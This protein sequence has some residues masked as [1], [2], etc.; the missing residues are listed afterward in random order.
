MLP[1]QTFAAHGERRMRVALLAGCVQQ[2]IDRNINAA[3]IRLL[4]RHGCEVVIATGAGCCGALPLHMGFEAHGKRLAHANVA[5]WSKELAAG[6]DAIVV[7]ASGCGTTVKD[8][9]HL[10]GDERA[11]TVAA[12]ARD[13]TELLDEIGMRAGAAAPYRVAYHDACSLAHGQ[14]VTRQPRELLARAGFEVVD[15]PERH[16]C[17]GSAGTY[18]LLQPEI[19]T[20]LGQ[21]KATH[22]D[23]TDADIVAAGN[24]GCM[25]QIARFTAQPI[26]H[27]VELLDWATGGPH[28]PALHN[29]R[30]RRP[31]PKGVPAASPALKARRRP[32]SQTPQPFGEPP[33]ARCRMGAANFESFFAEML[34]ELGSDGINRSSET[35]QRYGENT[36][37]GGDRPPAGVVY[38]DTTAQV[39]S[40]VRA[41]NRH[42]VPLYPISTGNNIGLGSRSASVAG[43]VVVDLGRRMNRVVEIDEKLA[44]AVVEPGVSY[45]M[46]Y[47]ELVRRGNRLMLDVTSG[48]PQG[49][50]IGNALDKGAGYSP[51]F[52]HFGFS[53]GLEIV[54]GN[55]EVLRTGDGSLDAPTL[56]NWRTSKYSFGPIL[57]G[58]FA[59]S[60]YGIVTRMGVWLLP[61]PPAIRSFHFAFPE[62]DDLDPIIELCRP[63]KLSN[64]VPTLFR[65]ANDLYLCGS[66]G[67]SPEYA[68]SNGKRAISDEGRRRLRERHGVGAWTV[69]GAFYGASAAALEPQ[70]Q[71]VRD[72]FGQS[73]K[74]RYISHDEAGSIPPLQVA[75]NAFSGI[76]SLGELGLL[77]WRPGGGNI[78]FLPGTPMDGR[79]ANEFQ[80]LCRKTY[81][82]FGLDYTVMNVCGA[83]FARGLHVITFNREDAD[84]RSRADACYRK[85][86]EQVRARGVFVGR[87][88]VDY[89]DFHM[90]QAMPA[91][92]NACADIKSRA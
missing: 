56:V 68:A 17:C 12:R 14:R 67:Q 81:E 78:W 55:G 53:C 62:D 5:A 69:S 74:A 90:Q 13:V 6:L 61:R 20:T 80:R 92:R 58:L 25:V 11:R 63:L 4:Q 64:F 84:E 1:A 86:S 24:L 52:D 88:P 30:L 45:Q 60:N 36:M 21:R 34:G 3:T 66:E 37:P 43:Q 7:N 75:I 28:P 44:F 76:P 72:L 18:N 73:A 23:S 33:K 19:A 48:P 26:V 31:S 83:R 71:R 79:I 8:Y 10:L 41:A 77:Q 9:G 38:P 15:V 16:F 27:T 59:Q 42:R 35:I 85:M 2:A 46:L 54:L 87:A 50:M 70:L 40:V 22:L 82:E 49:G 91:F 47:D 39:Q 89:H 51:Y 29:R 65:V 57:D 32:L